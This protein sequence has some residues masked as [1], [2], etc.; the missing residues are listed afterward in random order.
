MKGYP[1]GL[2]V[3]GVLF[4]ALLALGVTGTAG[5]ATGGAGATGNGDEI[6][7]SIL[8]AS[9]RT[10]AATTGGNGGTAP[11]CRT[12][13]LT[14]RQ[15]IFLL[16]V[17]ANMPELLTASFIDAIDEYTN[18]TVTATQTTAPPTA[19]TTTAATTNG[20]GTTGTA[21]GSTATASPVIP[22]TTLPPTTL[23]VVTD[24][25]VTYWELTV[26]ICDGV[27]DTMSVRPRTV[28]TEDLGA[29][30]IAGDFLR[31]STRLPP[32][33]VVMSP[34]PRLGP[35]GVITSTLVGEPVF[36]AVDP[37]GP[38]TD[39]VPFSGRTVEV[40]ATPEHMEVFGG[41]PEPTHRVERCIGFGSHYD[42]ASEES[43][44]V[45]ASSPQACVLSFEWATG[46]PRRNAWLGYVALEWAGRYR[47]DGGP[48]HRLDGLFSTSVFSIEVGELDTAITNSDLHAQ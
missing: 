34:P 19:P 44:G 43:V 2:V 9:L 33:V 21:P 14:D 3:L 20:P 29:S 12:R 7:T 28:A 8:A 24:P 6:I 31:H 46:P 40:E 42:P 15:I 25:N 18:A 48:W 11:V 13:V 30:A 38:V 1:A 22:R 39:S 37:P 23:P 17:T 10:P 45:Q 26:R 36:F 41:E 16:H 5:A 4:T 27:A 35:A 47:V 32:P